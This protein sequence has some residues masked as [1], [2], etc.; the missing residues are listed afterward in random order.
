M[1]PWCRV[2]RSSLGVGAMDRYCWR[3]WA[4]LATPPSCPCGRAMS[5]YDHFCPKCGQDTGKELR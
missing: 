3:C 1:S 2:C 5:I 4:E